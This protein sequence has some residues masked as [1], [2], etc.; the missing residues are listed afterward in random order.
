MAFLTGD[1]HVG[2]KVHLNRLIAVPFASLTTSAGDIK[3]ETPRLI[4]THFRFRKLHKKVAD[5]RK[6]TGISGRITARRTSDRRLVHIDD[7]IYIINSFNRFIRQRIFQGA[8]EM[9]A[10]NRLQGRINQRRLSATRHAG[11]TNQRPQREGDIHILQVIPA[12]PFYGDKLPVSFASFFRDRDLHLSVQISR[13]QRIRFQHLLRSSGIDHFTA[14]TAGL[15]SH[16][17]HIIRIEHHILVMLHHDDGVPRIAQLLQRIDQPDII[18][19]VQPDTRL[20]EDIQD[21]HQLT[22]DLRSQTDTLALATRQGC[23]STVQGQI[24]QSHIQQKLQA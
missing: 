18:P 10:E 20:V 3:R 6:D 21:I 13:S 5:I 24:I 19:L 7:L 11:H 17:D 2:Q 4:T 22:A 15:R 8:I 1:K 16:I 9:L 23:R 14:Q 12:C